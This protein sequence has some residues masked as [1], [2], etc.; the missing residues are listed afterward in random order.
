MPYKEPPKEHQFKKGESGNPSGRPKG[1]LKDYVAKKLR[2]M[3]DEEKEEYLEGINK[4]MVWKMGEGSPHQT[5]DQKIEVTLPE[6]LLGGKSQNGSHNE[7]NNKATE[8]D[9]ED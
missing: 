5:Q 1:T 4:E 9:K 3:P 8:T 6:P 7:S 2:E